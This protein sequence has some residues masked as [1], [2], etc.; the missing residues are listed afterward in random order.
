M[1]SYRAPFPYR[2][3]Q[4]SWE[5]LDRMPQ[6]R[7]F[8]DYYYGHSHASYRDDSGYPLYDED[9]GYLEDERRE[10]IDYRDGNPD[11]RER[12]DEYRRFEVGH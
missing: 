11:L 3:R 1:T 8:D 4:G 10:Y 7:D 2:E 9:E 5:E 6:R 12:D